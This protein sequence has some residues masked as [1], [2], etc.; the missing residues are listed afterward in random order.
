M[1]PGKFWTDSLVHDNAAL[2]L[3]VE[4]MGEDRVILGTDYPF[5]LGEILIS[6]TYPGKVIKESQFSSSRKSKLF[7]DNAMDFLNLDPSLY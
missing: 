7:W 4:E 2:E 3:L 6:D 1:V 5:P